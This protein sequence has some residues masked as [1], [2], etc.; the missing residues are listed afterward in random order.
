MAESK[1]VSFRVDQATADA[2][3]Q[4][5]A[6][7]TN[8][9]DMLNA[10]MNALEEQG[11]RTDLPADIAGRMEALDNYISGIKSVAV[12]MANA[13]KLAKQ[14][15]QDKVTAQ[16]T[17]K[18][19]TIMDL[20]GKI[21]ELQAELAQAQEQAQEQLAQAQATAQAQIAELQAELAQ[22]NKQFIALQTLNMDR[23]ISAVSSQP[24]Q[25]P[26][27]TE[28][29]PVMVDV[30]KPTRRKKASSQTQTPTGE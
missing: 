24:Q 6:G 22:V 18:D 23:L 29:A 7:F 10:L 19:N 11:A 27:P 1:T 4:V 20:Q 16:L 26:E 25:Q 13:F 2:L 12:D 14:T 15:A 8:K 5:A 17:A 3:E 9:Q 21:T 30:S 28:K